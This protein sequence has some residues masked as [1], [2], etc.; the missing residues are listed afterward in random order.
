MLT[1]SY[2]WICFFFQLGNDVVTVSVIT[3]KENIKINS[4]AEYCRLGVFYKVPLAS[5]KISYSLR[6]KTCTE[7]LLILQDKKDCNFDKN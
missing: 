2:Y 3:S 5:N 7:D 4:K 6:S 1:S